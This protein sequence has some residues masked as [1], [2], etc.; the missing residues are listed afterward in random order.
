MK[1]IRLKALR[2]GN[3]LNAGLGKK[4]FALNPMKNAAE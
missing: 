2:E 3:V 4:V 1:R